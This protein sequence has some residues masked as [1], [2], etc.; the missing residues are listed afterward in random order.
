MERKNCKGTNKVKYVKESNGIT[1]IALV[2]TIIVLL[3]LA[4]VTIATL[5]GE[6]G[7]LTRAQ[8][9]KNQT[10]EAEDIEKI[11]L[12]VSEAQIG[13]KGYQ[14]LDQNNLQEAIDNQFNGRNTIVS[15]NGDG[16]FTVSLDNKM[17]ELKNNEINELQVDLYINNAEDLKAFRDNV[18]NGITYEGKYVVLTSNI[19]L[20]IEDEWIPIGTYLPENTNVLDETNKPFKGNFNGQNHVID[21]LKITSKDKGKGLF[22]L[23]NAGSIQNLIIGENCNIDAGISFGSIS[24]YLC[25]NGTITNCSNKTNIKA[26]GTNLGGI[27]GTATEGCTIKKCTNSGILQGEI[28][29]GGIV[30]N[31]SGNIIYCSNLSTL[32]SE[33]IIGGICGNNNLGVI[34]ECYNIGNVT[35]ETTNAGGIVGSINGGSIENCYNVGNITGTG[36]NIGGIIGLGSGNSEASNSYNIGYITSSNNNGGGIIGYNQSIDILNC[37]YLI[38]SVNGGNGRIVAGCEFKSEEEMKNIAKILGNAFKED[39]KNINNGYPILNWQ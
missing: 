27:I 7:I 23:V 18:N 33:S 37:Y 1:L 31:N 35:T 20:D 4:G 25:S 2:I 28:I 11:R 17:Y 38:N 22:G 6:N 30:G 36:T 15:D 8:N 14:K 26:N 24:G 32:N 19:T 12:A 5:T 34:K 39:I 16:T 21:G 3:I 10:E 9:A 13:E 29:T